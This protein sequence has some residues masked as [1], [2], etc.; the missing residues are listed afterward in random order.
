MHFKAPWPEYKDLSL[1]CH[2]WVMWSTL[3]GTRA[4]A[5]ECG[6]VGRA[7]TLPTWHLFRWI[8]ATSIYLS[9]SISNMTHSPTR[10]SFV[11]H[12]GCWRLM[13]S[14]RISNHHFWQA[15]QAKVQM[16]LQTHSQ[17]FHTEAVSSNGMY[18]TVAFIC[19]FVSA[20]WHILYDI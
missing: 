10:M 1:D 16:L 5:G 8:T 17:R 4:G 9:S 11:I 7:V 19:I 2:L 20:D 15:K 3:D 13:D 18:I 12:F 6:G 14:F